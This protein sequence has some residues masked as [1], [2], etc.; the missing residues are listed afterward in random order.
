MYE[1]R[2]SLA[3]H[4][5]NDG[6]WERDLRTDTV[7]FSP[8]WKQMLGYTDHE[9]PNHFSEWIKRV[10]PDDLAHV[11]L[12]ALQLQIDGYADTYEFDHRVQHKDGTYRWICARGS[13]LRDDLNSIY[14]IAGWHTDIT[15]RKL[16]EEMQVWRTRHAALRVDVSTALTERT[17]LPTILQR[18]TEAMVLHLHAAFARIW[19]LTPGEDVLVLQA[20]AGKYTHLNGSH[21]LI[22]LGAL[23]I[24]RIAQTRLPYLTNDVLNDPHIN[25]R[26]W[27]H[28]EGMI[29]FAGYPLL[30]EDQVV[31]VMAM[32][33]QEPLLEDTLDALA[34]V[35]YTIAQG[36]GRKWAEEH[37]EE[38][39]KQRT[40][41]LTLLLEEN[42]RLYAQS[43]ELAILQ[44]RQRLA[45]E[46]HDSVSQALYG[47]VLG[48]RTAS[49]LLARDPCHE[50]NINLSN[51][52]DSLQKQAETGLTEMRTL[53]FELR[54]ESLE[55]EGLVTALKKHV[56]I[57][58]TRY[59]LQIEVHLCAEPSLPFLAKEALYRIVQ[60]A[61]H[62]IVKHAHVTTAQLRLSQDI[63]GILLEIRDNGVGF[64][65]ANY[66]PGHL[67]L[68]S[69]RE[70]LAHLGGSLEITS[71]P[72][73]GTQIR[74]L[75]P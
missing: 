39:V 14:R 30:V 32:F 13:A 6:W 7:Y 40:R 23:K 71:V 46:L 73:Q 36:I 1:E 20:S 33:S 35:A 68:Q 61:L 22:P 34:T 66:F 65:P 21:S 56:E 59:G 47:I 45:R 24:G 55:T 17:T 44:E 72:G 70:R 38:R 51:L 25:N 48:M 57:V 67:G 62:N 15:N 64:N 11:V 41:E 8:R 16:E 29:S 54:P 43:Q 5:S 19:T 4:G 53:I 12:S 10:H 2:F 31:G 58:Q 50:A 37:L 63:T 27:A 26:E 9:L 60:E 74:A 75:L 52:L 42:S 18:C 69:M 49:V 28:A 3:I